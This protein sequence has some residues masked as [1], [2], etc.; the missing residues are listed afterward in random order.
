MARRAD[1]ET[2]YVRDKR[3][4]FTRGTWC[5]SALRCT[6]RRSLGTFR[7]SRISRTCKFNHSVPCHNLEVHSAPERSNGRRSR[8]AGPYE[9]RICLRQTRFRRVHKKRFGVQVRTTFRFQRRCGS[10]T[11]KQCASTAFPRDF[12]G[13]ICGARSTVPRQLGKR[14]RLRRGSRQYRNES[15]DQRSFL[16]WHQSDPQNSTTSGRRSALVPFGDT[17]ELWQATVY[18]RQEPAAEE[19]Q[20]E[21]VDTCPT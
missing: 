3:G 6:V 19:K 14:K 1:S 21:R 15:P 16:V 4:K 7:L 5:G 20:E 11:W 12:H 10:Y 8:D 18:R 17:C 13:H 9:N 2:E